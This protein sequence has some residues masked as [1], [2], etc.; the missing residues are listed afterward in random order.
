MHMGHSD[1]VPL[2]KSIMDCGLQ[3]DIV[4]DYAGKDGSEIKRQANTFGLESIVKDYG[5]LSRFDTAKLQVQSDIFLVISWNT[6][7]DQGI[8]TGKFYEALQHKKP[9]IAIVSGDIPNSELAV[10][11]K[12]YNL[13]YCYEEAEALDSYRDIKSYLTTQCNLKKQGQH[14]KY[15]PDVTVYEKFEYGNIVKELERILLSTNG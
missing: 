11:I 7:N 10:L 8:L 13:G 15:E 2:F 4:I 9:I 6:K 14:L 1:S 12:R 5:Y 3:N